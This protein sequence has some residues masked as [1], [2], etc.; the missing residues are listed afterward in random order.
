MPSIFTTALRPL[1]TDPSRA[2]AGTYTPAGGAAVAVPMF[3][4][5]RDPAI[6]IGIG[7]ARAAGRVVALRVADV[8]TRP[9]KN[10]QVVGNGQSYAIRDVD[11]DALNGRWL[12]DVDSL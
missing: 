10:D 12:C 9:K 3:F 8:P 1:F 6:D 2:V 4:T 5:T 11:T 7:T